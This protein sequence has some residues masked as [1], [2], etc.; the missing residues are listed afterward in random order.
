L[1]NITLNLF[2]IPRYG[3]LG[4]TIATLLTQVAA[5]ILHILAANREFGFEYEVKEIF[6]MF[7]FIILCWA[8]LLFIQLLPLHWMMAFGF[9]IIVCTGMAIATSLLPIKDALR[10]IKSRF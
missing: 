4:A 1:L 3:A 9:S 10:L 7:A 5:A 8:S 6:K 2:L